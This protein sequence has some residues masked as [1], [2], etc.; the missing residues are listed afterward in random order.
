LAD[1]DRGEEYFIY[2]SGGAG[3]ECVAFENPKPGV[4]YLNRLSVLPKYRFNG[5]GEEL[6]SET[7]VYRRGNKDLPT[8]SI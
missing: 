5:V 8:S 2:K 4:A 6:V 3:I 1:F 7:R